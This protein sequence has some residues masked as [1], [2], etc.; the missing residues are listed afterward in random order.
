[1]QLAVKEWRVQFN[2]AERNVRVHEISSGFRASQLAPGDPDPV[3]GPHRAFTMIWP[4]G[5]RNR[6]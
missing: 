3:L 2:V 6:S 1:M 4:A 5:N